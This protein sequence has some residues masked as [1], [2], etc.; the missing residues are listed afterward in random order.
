M[1]AKVLSFQQKKS[2]TIEKKRRAF[3]RIMFQNVMGV[4]TVIDKVNSIYPIELVDISHDGCLFQVPHNPKTDAKFKAEEEFTL[5]IYFTESSYVPV[6]VKVKHGTEFTHNDGRRFMRYGCEFDK[7]TSGFE[8]I[9]S[10]VDFLCR[11]AEHSMIDRGDNKVY[12]L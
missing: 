12:F 3:E 9:T 2:E 1:S 5:R 11:F 7:T 8:T 10:F 4:Y 6:I